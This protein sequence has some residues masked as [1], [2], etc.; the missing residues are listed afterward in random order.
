MRIVL[1][2]YLNNRINCKKNSSANSFDNPS[3]SAQTFFSKKNI[4]AFI[5]KASVESKP[6]EKMFDDIYRHFS[7][8]RSNKFMFYIQPDK[9]DNKFVHV[10]AELISYQVALD[11]AKKYK[12][13][14]TLDEYEK[15]LKRQRYMESDLQKPLTIYKTN[16]L[17]DSRQFNLEQGD[18]EKILEDIKN[19]FPKDCEKDVFLGFVRRKRGLL[20][21][22]YR[23]LDTHGP[24]EPPIY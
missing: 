3:F 2:R 11:L 7:S 12:K 4:D 16:T 6:I 14:L 18:N 8:I 9:N 24:D 17:S 20:T 15:I 19:K 13:Y 21:R 5:K 23:W 1:D 22:I 10:S